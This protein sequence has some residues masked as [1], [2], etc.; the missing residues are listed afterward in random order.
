MFRKWRASYCCFSSVVIRNDG[1]KI[2]HFSSLPFLFRR[3]LSST[4]NAPCALNSK[5]KSLCISDRQANTEIVI[6]FDWYRGMWNACYGHTWFS[7]L[8]ELFFLFLCADISADIRAGRQGRS[9][10]T[11]EEIFSL[12]FTKHHTFCFCCSRKFAKCRFRSGCEFWHRNIFTTLLSI[13]ASSRC[14]HWRSE[15]ILG[16]FLCCWDFFYFR[17]KNH[18]CCWRFFLFTARCSTSNETNLRINISCLFSFWFLR[19]IKM[20]WLF[21]LIKVTFLIRISSDSMLIE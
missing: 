5:F 1:I 4:E 20:L 12:C 3:F 19:N 10:S 14:A 11:E 8:L 21:L 6:S 15:C 2:A 17:N 18:C 7:L 13:D 16:S 9:A